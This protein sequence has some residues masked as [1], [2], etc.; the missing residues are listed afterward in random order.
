MLNQ[1]MLQGLKEVIF[2]KSKLPETV[3]EPVHIAVK[4]IVTLE[5]GYGDFL[6]REISGEGV[7]GDAIRVLITLHGGD[8]S[9]FNTWFQQYEGA[10]A[11]G[12]RTM[13][14]GTESIWGS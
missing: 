3:K 12:V 7:R 9:E 11:E 8:V 4:T 6:S 13:E 5:Y 2:E 1:E 10:N 14:A